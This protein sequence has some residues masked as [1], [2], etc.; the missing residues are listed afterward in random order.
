MA[1]LAG[2]GAARAEWTS[3]GP[4]GGAAEIV[5]VSPLEPGLVLAGAA[6]G[7]LYRS[8]NGGASWSHLAFPAQLA[9]TLHDLAIDP[10]VRGVWYAA[11]ESDNRAIAGLYKTEDGGARWRPLDGLRGHSVWS[12]ALWP[13]DPHWVAAGTS[14]GIFLSG[15]SG[16]SWT[17]LS[18]ES[19]TEL[20]PVVSLAFDPADR[21]ILY[22]GTLHLPWRT[23][24]GGAS[25]QSIHDGMIDDSDVFSIAVEAHAPESV[26]A[27]ACSGVYRS[28]NGGA[29]W[30]RLN[31]PHGAFRTY[32]VALD[33][34][35]PGVVFAAT[36][37]GLLRSADRGAAWITVTPHAVKS[38]AFDP[39][40]PQKIFLASTTGGLLVSRDGGRT[41]AEFNTGFVNRNF[42]AVA[43]SGATLYA[44]SVYEPASGGLFRSRNR[45]LR[46]DRV[47]APEGENIVRLAAA[48]DHPEVV[49]AAGYQA[50]FRSS[51]GGDTWSKPSAPPGG[52]SIQALAAVAGGKLLA[53][54]GASLF[55]LGHNEW[56]PIALPRAGTIEQLQASP[57]G[58][59]AVLT[60]AGASR[61]QDG[62]ATWT[63]CGQPMADAVWYGLAFDAG[64]G[65][66]AFAA[67]SRGLYR[68]ADSCASWSPVRNGLE[69]ATASAVVCHP[70]HP[71][72]AFV[73]QSGRVLV[74]SDGGVSWIPLAADGP[75]HAFPDSLFFLSG[76]A[77]RLFA[78]F[79]RLGLFSHAID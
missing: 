7:L 10:R 35:H 22:A 28:Q 13:A 20:R 21:R 75:T 26:F 19:N 57:G 14:D 24:D 42:T 53:G 40:N 37:A 55:A 56:Q 49:Y 71:G 12:L 79:P 34:A 62:G 2:A 43:T 11:M 66:L 68:S 45:G 48:P 52:G 60:A 78:W 46:W 67:T 32:L 33:P 63:G 65:G 38:M 44:A 73:A 50:I 27:S 39:A 1:V 72:E 8:R 36:S 23:R 58:M 4:F 41:V 16:A 59:L 15:D 70:D 61:S 25:W 51:D 3:S 6:N 54:A 74:T 69:E 76:A 29:A 31:T 5:R 47:A 17:R 77:G 30:S 18:P 9:G 64:R